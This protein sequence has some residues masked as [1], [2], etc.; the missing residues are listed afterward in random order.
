[1]KVIIDG[2][3]YIKKVDVPTDN[4]YEKALNIRIDSDAG[5][6]ITIRDYFF[7]LLKTLWEKED[8][9]SG[10]GNSDWQYEIYEALIKHGF[11]DGEL[12]EDGYVKKFNRFEVDKF[13][14]EMI[15]VAFYGEK[16]ES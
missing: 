6:N 2:Q 3:E 9:F 5:D 1:M 16:S 14:E 4:K 7:E 13:I 10:F 15:K 12:D 11:V 8:Y